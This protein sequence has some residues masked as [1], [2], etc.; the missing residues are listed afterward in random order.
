MTNGDCV[1]L[2][3]FPL[4]I[5]VYT[6]IHYIFIYSDY[7]KKEWKRNKKKQFRLKAY[8]RETF[9]DGKRPEQLE[10]NL[11]CDRDRYC[12]YAHTF[13]H[14]TH[15]DMRSTERY[16]KCVAFISFLLLIFLISF[17][18]LH[19]NV[20]IPQLKKKNNFFIRICY[21]HIIHFVFLILLYLNIWSHNLFEVHFMP[22]ANTYCIC[23]SLAQLEFGIY[24]LLIYLSFLF[25]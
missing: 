15:T 25:N 23:I 9:S 16:R 11:K 18:A 7:W 20:N 8:T 14:K 13:I 4:F 10:S 5:Y 1:A 6:Y 24:C 22:Y 12:T 17:F 21:L 19:F 2:K 3:H